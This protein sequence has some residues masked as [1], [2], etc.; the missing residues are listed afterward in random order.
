MSKKVKIKVTEEVLAMLLTLV[1]QSGNQHT[2]R[3]AE[4][5]WKYSAKHVRAGALAE[6]LSVE[7]DWW[8]GTASVLIEM[9]NYLDER[10]ED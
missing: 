5:Y 1:S 7:M 3:L 10:E 2:P 9:E 4:F 6:D 8:L